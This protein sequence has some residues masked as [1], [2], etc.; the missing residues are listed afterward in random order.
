MTSYNNVQSQSFPNFH[1]YNQ[2]IP[3]IKTS[4]EPPPEPVKVEPPKVE[5]PK[6]MTKN[7]SAFDDLVVTSNPAPG[8]T[9]SANPFDQHTMPAAPAASN[10]GYSHQPV[11]APS[12]PANHYNPNP[13]AGYPQQ[14]PYAVPPNQGYGAPQPQYHPGAYPQHY[15]YPPASAPYGAGPGYA[16]AYGYSYPP[17]PQQFNAPPA[18]Y[19]GPQ[20]TGQPAYHPNNPPQ[21]NPSKSP[22]LAAAPDPFSDMTGL[23]WSNLQKAAPPQLVKAN[24]GG[25]SAPPA[26]AQ[27]IYPEPQASEPVASNPFDMFG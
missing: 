14:N 6:E 21:N 15:N 7:F 11:A 27:T 22:V 18:G 26:P 3:F 4:A 19:P 1:G 8:Q 17:P 2:P 23:A 20:Q 10:P 24:L 12:N 5:A 25:P 13:Y 16:A 9:T